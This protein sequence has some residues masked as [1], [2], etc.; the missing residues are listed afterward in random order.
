MDGDTT[1]RL[2]SLLDRMNSG[3]AEAR[4]ELIGRAYGRLRLLAGAILN[5]SFPALRNRHDLDSVLHDSFIRLAQA[6]DSVTAPTVADFFRLAARK[7]NHV[8][9]DLIDRHR[10]HD[11]GTPSDF[12]SEPS[13]Q[14]HDPARLALWA[15]FHAHA[16]RLPDGPREVFELQYYLDLSQA[17][18]AALL[19]LHPRKV[20]RLW[21]SAKDHLAAALPDGER[22]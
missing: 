18:I 4:C 20:S 17:E 12:A 22:S 2:Q 11:C 13:D 15:E 19:N 10:R 7:I 8:L 1:L 9:L 16:A 3:D 5:R 14:S 21:Q 6:L